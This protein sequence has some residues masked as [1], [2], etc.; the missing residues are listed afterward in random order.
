MTAIKKSR[1][2]KKRIKESTQKDL[3]GYEKAVIEE[4][5][6]RNNIEDISKKS[7]DVR[8]EALEL[9]D[10]KIILKSE[11]NKKAHIM[12]NRLNS[13]YNI[14]ILLG[15]MKNAKVVELK[16]KRGEIRSF[17]TVNNASKVVE[18]LGFDMALISY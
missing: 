16:T 10:L 5:S 12:R 7:E 17:K 3:I 9:N 8:R 13:I 18:Q 15:P 14:V 6:I 2:E 4:K 1:R 11:K